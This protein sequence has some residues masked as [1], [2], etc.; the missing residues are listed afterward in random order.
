LNLEPSEYPYIPL[1]SPESGFGVAFL[2]DGFDRNF[3]KKAV[4]D[5][6]KV[7][8]HGNVGQHGVKNT[9]INYDRQRD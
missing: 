3:V 2:M 6:V 7:R 4:G 1:R 8:P 5:S 9:G